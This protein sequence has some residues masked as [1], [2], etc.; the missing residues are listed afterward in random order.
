LKLADII[1]DWSD[2]DEEIKWVEVQSNYSSSSGSG[3]EGCE[4]LPLPP[5]SP[6]VKQALRDGRSG[7]VWG[8]VGD[9][10]CSLINV[11][12]WHFQ[13]EKMFPDASCFFLCR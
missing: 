5:F 9:L 3:G 2:E 4:P 1:D 7:E 8:L 12:F 10:F 13:P 6:A 11:A